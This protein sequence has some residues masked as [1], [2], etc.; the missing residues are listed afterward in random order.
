MVGFLSDKYIR[1]A[2]TLFFLFMFMLM[3]DFI[4]KADTIYQVTPESDLQEI[5]DS[6]N[7]SEQNKVIIY[8][9]SGIY[10]P[11]SA[12][13]SMGMPERYISFIGLSDGVEI[14]S[15]S[16]LYKNPAADLRLNGRVEN[17]R[18][19][20]SHPD[21]ELNVE[22]KGAYAVHADYGSQHTVFSD[23]TFISYQASAVGMGLT[24]DSEMIFKD[25]HFINRATAKF[26]SYWRMGAILAHTPELESGTS[27]A[28]LT[29]EHCI[30]EYP[31]ESY[32]GVI[33]SELNGSEVDFKEI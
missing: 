17:I 18:F 1:T 3:F 14:L 9:H 23:C 7:D 33:V 2:K 15:E 30:Y 13:S 22:D 6:C 21:G 5:I 4:A 27:G 26:G 12:I 25:C 20:A 32:A 28:K 29:L 19:I 8:M 10:K 31:G 24:Y 16:G 11:F